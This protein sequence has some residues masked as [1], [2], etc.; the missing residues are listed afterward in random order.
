[1]SEQNRAFIPVNVAVLTVSD[2]RTHKTDKSGP[3]L[4]ERARES[5][6]VVVDTA[7]VKDDVYQIRAAVS[8]WVS[9]S[10]INVILTT[11]GTGVTGRDGTPE[12]VAPLLDKQIPGFGEMFRAQSYESIGASTLQSRALAELGNSKRGW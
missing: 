5:G 9:N 3:L 1:M 6:H 8:A 12:A 7:I 10:Q 4:V 2:S 11:G